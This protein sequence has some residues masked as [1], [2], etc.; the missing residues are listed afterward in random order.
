MNITA[1]DISTIPN[2]Q[3]GTEVIL[4]GDHPHIRANDLA[5]QEGL[6]TREITTTIN[7]LIE[8]IVV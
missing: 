5:V 3:I 8:R 1:I 2:A 4:I 7:P 6:N